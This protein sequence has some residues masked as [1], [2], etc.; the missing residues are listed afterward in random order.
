[1]NNCTFKIRTSPGTYNPPRHIV[2]GRIVSSDTTGLYN[3]HPGFTGART[4]LAEDKMLRAGSRL[5]G[6]QG[7]EVGQS[8]GD[9]SGLIHHTA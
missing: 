5:P 3:T 2:A 1:M 7:P 8:R 9:S 6:R 4:R